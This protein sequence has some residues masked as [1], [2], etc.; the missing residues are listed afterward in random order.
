[1]VNF[2]SAWT[3]ERFGRA[4]RRQV[5]VLS[6]ELVSAGAAD[7][8]D[9]ASQ[10]QHYR[11]DVATIVNRHG[12]RIAGDISGNIL[13]VWG[14]S[15][16]QPS[17]CSQPNGW[18]AFAK[19]APRF[20]ILAAL[21]IAAQRYQQTAVRI[22]IDAGIVVVSP[23]YGSTA[24][25]SL[26]ASI[27]D[28]VGRVLGD[29]RALR[30]QSR[31]HTVLVSDAVRLLATD[32][33]VFETHACGQSIGG[34]STGSLMASPVWIVS[35]CKPMPR[36]HDRRAPRLIGNAR[37][38][39]AL[40]QTLAQGRKVIVVT[41][42]AGIGK[43]TLFRHFRAQVNASTARWI[44]ST[45]RPEHAHA[46]L[47]P[48]RDLLQNALSPAEIDWLTQA[49]PQTP[50]AEPPVAM[51]DA[52]DRQ[53]LSRFF[54]ADGQSE[55][56]GPQLRGASA[57]HAWPSDRQ[58]RLANLLIEIIGHAVKSQ[59]TILAIEDL[60][61]ADAGT[62]AFVGL[63]VERSARWRHF[64]LA[65]VAR[66]GDHLPKSVMRRAAVVAVDRLNDGEIV[67]LLAHLAA[68]ATLTP[69]I[70]RLIAH[71]AEG[72]PLFAEQ[73]AAL[74]VDTDPAQASA[75]LAGPTSLNL[76]LAARLD[77][78]GV[79]KS[80]AQAASVFGRDFDLPVLAR[81]LGIAPAQLQ[82]ELAVLESS[83]LVTLVT[84]RSHV[85]YR[86]SH[87]LVRDAAY[88]SL[89][90][91]QRRELHARAADAITQVF[92]ALAQ[93]SPEAMALHY[94]E[95]GDG[96]AAAR[97][98]RMAAIGAIELS[99]LSVAIAHLQ[100]ALALLA[101]ETTQDAPRSGIDD[102]AR[103]TMARGEELAIRR[104]LAPCLTTLA[105][106]GADAVIGNY[107]RGLQLTEAS[108]P[109][110]FEILWG[111]QGCHAVRGELAEALAWGDQAIAAAE[112]AAAIAPN[113]G[114]SGHGDEQCLLAHRMQGLARLQA[115]EITQ[116][117]GHFREVERRY[118]PV[119]HAAMRFRYVSD[120]G[121]LAQAHW[122]WAEAVAGNLAASEHLAERAL[123]RAGQ[124][125]HPHTS[126]HVVSVL[127]A[128][129]QTL[130]QREVAAPLALAA[131]TLGH[132]HGFTYWSAWAE[133]ILGWHEGAHAPE[134]S[135]GRIERAIQDYRRTGAGQALPYALL[136]K[137]E[138][139]LGAGLSDLAARAC[140]EGL[141]LARA[142]GINLYA[143]ELLRV[144][145]LALV[146]TA[147]QPE[148]CDEPAASAEAQQALEDAMALSVGQG[149]RIFA[150][151]A[152][153]TQLRGLDAVKQAL[154]PRNGAD[155]A[156][157]RAGAVLRQVLAE[158][159]GVARHRTPPA[160]SEIMEATAVAA[161]L[162]D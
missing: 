47:Q 7:P 147:T 152:A 158:M 113:D 95:A 57:D 77:A 59:P 133:I 5:T 64:G 124:L 150:M 1:M 130:G 19:S 145:A 104:L 88:A 74:Y 148:Q 51:L 69:E 142:G 143:G 126:A 18:L 78:L 42:E 71:R 6:C 116:A 94:G 76:T 117:I 118:D 111:L 37:Q 141:Q 140:A 80:L 99:Q 149:T 32:A 9:V 13:A 109:A 41:G 21:D 96:M 83:G 25:A 87:A 100:R 138:V 20:A 81:M 14:C 43:S 139:A 48:I 58:Q 79:T 56:Q 30:T 112:T 45:C 36:L 15:D 31:D 146:H 12:G 73:L 91:Q 97:W 121:V 90:K 10:L 22:A 132:A 68:G 52:A 162:P 65:L 155:A 40:D 67:E 93:A 84:D 23:A 62:L 151:R 27:G 46:I 28:L 128:R 44:E 127:A 8:E 49:T 33:F 102:L 34:Q 107:R 60:H 131:R 85:S 101:N 29:A 3:N 86:F 17:A 119:R 153:V 72:V 16:T 53:L 106:N 160:S 92:P 156:Q 35:A 24:G 114:G 54:S 98:W 110:P 103:E 154:P 55:G 136:L 39:A 38:L 134:Q 70:L 161:A 125:E 115:G 144:R 82:A 157:R 75:I 135:I 63:L 2:A 66:R 122:A 50:L 120:Q 4:E 105:G 123:A 159:A 129:A 108:A 11:A 61:W 137:A 89:L 26:N